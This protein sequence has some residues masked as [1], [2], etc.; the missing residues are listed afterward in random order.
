M[1]GLEEVNLTYEETEAIRLKDLH[2]M[3]QK[4]AA[5]KMNISQPTF[6]R[7]LVS[8]RKKIAEALCN[9]KAI[10]IRGGNFVVGKRRRRGGRGI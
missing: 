2:E 9:G 3:S 5:E 6:H 10:Q 1:R 8:G 4:E 7:I